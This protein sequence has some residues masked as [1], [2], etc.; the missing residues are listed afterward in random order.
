VQPDYCGGHGPFCTDGKGGWLV[1][2]DQPANGTGLAFDPFFVW[3]AHERR[4]L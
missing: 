3:S 4:F 2:C 1:C